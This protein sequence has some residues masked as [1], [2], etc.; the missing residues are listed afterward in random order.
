[1]DDLDNIIGP[2][3]IGETLEFIVRT[4]EGAEDTHTETVQS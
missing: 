4:K 2:V 3:A 1:M